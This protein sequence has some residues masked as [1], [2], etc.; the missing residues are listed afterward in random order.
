MDD[1]RRTLYDTFLDS[2]EL[3]AILPEATGIWEK[4]KKQ[5][6]KM[7]EDL[8]GTLLEADSSWEDS[9]KNPEDRYIMGI[10]PYYDEE[11]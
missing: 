8:E 4:D 5:F 3:E 2:G 10:D 7:Q 9:E 11:F 6:R 1:T